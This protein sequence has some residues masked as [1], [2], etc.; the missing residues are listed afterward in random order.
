MLTS[1]FGIS[2]KCEAWKHQDS[3]PVYIAGSYDFQTAYIGN[4]RCIMLIPT[5]ELATL[6]ALKK[7]ITKIQQI[8]N[9]PVVFELATVSNYHPISYTCK[10]STTVTT[11]CGRLHRY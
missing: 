1:V 7:Q 6:P 11:N 8:D 10:M 4:K 5:E 9:V 2:I 3:L